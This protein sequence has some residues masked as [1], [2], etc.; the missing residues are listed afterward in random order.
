DPVYYLLY[1]LVRLDYNWK[2]ILYLYYTK[3]TKKDN[4]IFFRYININIIK[5]V[6]TGCSTNII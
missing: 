6:K 4:S 2:L 3:Y 5:A 1:I